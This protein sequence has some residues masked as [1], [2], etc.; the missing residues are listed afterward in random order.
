[1]AGVT[2]DELLAG[3]DAMTRFLEEDAAAKARRLGVRVE[4]VGVKDVVLPGEMKTLLN[5]VIEAEKE[6]AA[7]VILRREETAATRSLANTARLMA[8]QP[9]LLRLKELDSLKEMAAKVQ[10][11]RIVVGANA[12]AGLVPSG[13]FAAATRIGRGIG[14]PRVAVNH[15]LSGHCRFESCPI[16]STI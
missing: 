3:R 2:L 4:R 9:L 5:K 7:N 16:H 11:V 12:M 13:F 1:M 15:V 14:W 8:E 6:A 10:E